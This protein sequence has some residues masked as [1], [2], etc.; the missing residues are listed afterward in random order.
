M[1]YIV[2]GHENAD[3]DSI[4]SGYLL[5][6]VMTKKG[7]DVSFVI[8]DED[9]SNESEDLCSKYDLSLDEYKNKQLEDDAKYI[10][11][12]HNVRDVPGEIVAIID[13]HP[14]L[15][16]ASCDNCYIEDA[17]STACMIAMKC[18]EYLDKHDIELSCL[19][20]FVDTASFHSTKTRKSD[21]SWINEMCT[22]YEFDY[23]KLYVDGLCLNSLKNVDEIL[24]NGFK[25][26]EYEELSIHS[27][28]IQVADYKKSQH[29]ID[30]I[31]GKLKDYV[32]EEKIDLY[33]FI[34]YDMSVF[35][36]KVYKISLDNVEEN[37]YF[38]YASRGNT[39]IP[40]VIKNYKK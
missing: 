18:E 30:K 36:T 5:E 31:I 12:D 8:T 19:A 29:I 23:D 10:L 33:V 34:I 21:I 24:F 11:V 1:K 6:K 13:H 22:K 2:L 37:E 17:S 40:E 4:V 25:K 20:T 16:E 14:I 15:K 32:K 3:V 26:Y 38:L 39:I 27:S 28:Y 7:Y 35:Y 9:L